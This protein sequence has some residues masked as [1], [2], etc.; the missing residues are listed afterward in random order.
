MEPWQSWAVVALGA[1]AA[2]YYYNAKTNVKSPP[3]ASQSTAE[4]SRARPNRKKEEQRSKSKDQGI[5]A[6]KSNVQDQSRSIPISSKNVGSEDQIRKRKPAKTTSE[7]ISGKS[8]AQQKDK[9]EGSG[10]MNDLDFA[11][12]LS[13]AKIGTS[14]KSNVRSDSPRKSMKQSAISLA[15][16]MSSTPSN[17]GIDADDNTSPI[18]SPQLD[19]S[20]NYK[21]SEGV[22]VS[23]MLEPSP[24]GPSVLKLKESNDS[25]QEKRSKQ[26][27]DVQSQETKKQ[28]Q[29]R[30]KVEEN[31]LQREEQEK[32]RLA[33]LEKQRRTAR[34]ARG[35]PAKNGLGNVTSSG[36]SV[37]KNKSSSTSSSTKKAELP[38]TVALLDTYDANESSKTKS[39]GPNG[40]RG[41]SANP[42]AEWENGIPSEEDQLRL[43]KEQDESNWNTVGKKSKKKSA[44]TTN[45]HAAGNDSSDAGSRD[46]PVTKVSQL[47]KPVNGANGPNDTANTFGS[48]DFRGKSHPNDSDWAVV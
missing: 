7:G 12:S 1:G 3:V 14:L 2:Y 13:S 9:P 6:Q 34:E 44:P 10:E 22:D 25:T 46:H 4:R 45:G 32:E 11:R 15:P 33:L 20:K 31:K 28:R 38:A 42:N 43:I 35:E 16:N 21:N 23:D 18:A 17:S 5:P 30:R 27:R 24:A 48:F 47:P 41:S 36:D 26:K 19:A 40:Y 8:P 29:N 37:W 39:N